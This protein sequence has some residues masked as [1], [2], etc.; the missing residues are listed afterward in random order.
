MSQ[1]T[2]DIDT[3]V[4]FTLKDGTEIETDMPMGAEFFFPGSGL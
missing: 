2:P 3:A 1:V 4:Q